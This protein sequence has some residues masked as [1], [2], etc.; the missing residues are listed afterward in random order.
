MI[1][2][3]LIEAAL[4]EKQDYTGKVTI[5]GTGGEFTNGGNFYQL[6]EAA[7][8]KKADFLGESTDLEQN[9]DGIQRS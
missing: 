3:E 9:E 2:Q 7:L 4:P 8:H 5:C 6:Y 1:I